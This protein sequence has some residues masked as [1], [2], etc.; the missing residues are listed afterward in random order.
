VKQQ[1]SVSDVDQARPDEKSVITYVASYY[2]TFARMKNEMKGGR[3]IAKVSTSL[4][5]L[6]LGLMVNSV[7]V[8]QT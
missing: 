3:R 4:H 7:T 2:H 5:G 1:L 8:A 6:D